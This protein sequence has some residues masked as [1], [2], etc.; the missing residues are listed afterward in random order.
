M[1]PF[2]S[3][4]TRRFFVGGVSVIVER[5]RGG[6]GVEGGREG[7]DEDVGLRSSKIELLDDVIYTQIR[8]ATRLLI[9]GTRIR[10]LDFLAR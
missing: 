4:R 1:L 6:V 8:E 5:G 2:G 3:S 9:F 7:E 10:S